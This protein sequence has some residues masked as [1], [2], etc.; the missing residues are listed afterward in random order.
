LPRSLRSGSNGKNAIEERM[1]CF[2]IEKSQ[3]RFCRNDKVKANRFEI[4]ERVFS[5]LLGGIRQK[6]MSRGKIPAR[7]T[8][9]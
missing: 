7:L 9:L 6:K 3:K 8:L 5:E 1:V 2:A 4:S